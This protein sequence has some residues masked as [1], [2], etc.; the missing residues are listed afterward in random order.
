MRVR[1]QRMAASLVGIGTACQAASGLRCPDDARR[2]RARGARRARR[3]RGARLGRGRLGRRR[4][5]RAPDA[6]S[7]RPGSRG[8]RRR[9]RPRTCG[10]GARRL[11]YRAHADD[12]PVRLVVAAPDG[13]S[14]DLHPIR[15]RA[16]RLG[17]PGA[18]TTGE[19]LLSGRRLHD[20]PDRWHRGRLSRRGG[21][22]R[23][24]F[25][26]RA[27]SGRPPRSRA[28]GRARRRSA[29]RRHRERGAG[30]GED[31]PSPPVSRRGVAPGS[32]SRPTALQRHDR[33]RRAVGATRRRGP[34]RTG[35]SA[36]RTRA[37]AGASPTSYV[38]AGFVAVVDDIYVT[39]DRLD[40]VRSPTRRRARSGSWC[41]RPHRSR[42][43]AP[44]TRRVRTRRSATGGCTSTRSSAT[45]LGRRRTLDRL[46]RR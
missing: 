31:A 36:I 18:A 6:G 30:R 1:D 15:F 13:R 25:A 26:L 39:R 27:A 45:E 22:T 32:T 19:Y 3:R 16:R 42:S 38:H 14:V 29:R 46:D 21:R 7:R 43:C 41:S 34:R 28:A 11:G 4:P 37:S 2:R 5:R 24:P 10:R 12:L 8:R 33:R 17:A 9:R 35:S 44:G 20:R 40:A 23:V